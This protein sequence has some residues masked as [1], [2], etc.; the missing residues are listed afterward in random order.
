M[1]PRIA[2]L[3]MAVLWG[4]S[5]SIVKDALS[6]TSPLTFN[7]LRMAIAAAIL[8]I[9]H[10]K[11]LRQ[12]TRENLVSASFVG[13]FLALGFQLQTL[14]LARTTPTKSA[15]ITGL[16]I[17]FVPCTTIISKLRPANAPKPG[18]AVFAGALIALAGL[19]FLTTPPAT[20]L[21]QLLTT[22]NTGDWL[23]LACAIAFSGHLLSMSHMATKVPT[24][25][26]VT[27]QIVLT[28]LITAITL[29]LG[30]PISLAIPHRV[31]PAL[32]ITS[33]FCTV[34]AFSVQTWAQQH[35]P[36][37]H[38][39]LLLTL[40]PVFAWLNSIVWFHEHLTQ[41]SLL[42]AALIL[43]GTVVVLLTGGEPTPTE[44]PA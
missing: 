22:I 44:I 38:T 10:G 16:V 8:L 41:R 42:G 21:R 35:V 26:L 30:G 12:I 17:V 31:I 32:L 4:I 33:I 34:L 14:R 37:V 40:E 7:F 36:P 11:Q 9:M 20:P 15:L 27:M 29:P 25:Q 1:K 18:I 3:A 13:L 6:S 28:S 5:F 24:N 39:A 2:L 19:V 43:G 23:T